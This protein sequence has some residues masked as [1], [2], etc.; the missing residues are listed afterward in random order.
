MRC[1]KPVKIKSTGGTSVLVRCG[2]CMS[3]RIDHSREWTARILLES[4]LH[5]Y[6]TFVT[7]TYDEE[8]LPPGGTL[9]K[10]ELSGFVKRLR[11]RFPP[12]SVRY[13][14]V[15]EYGDESGRP[16]YHIALF[17]VS[18]LSEQAVVDSW[19]D[20]QGN[21]LGFVKLDELN[22]GTAGYISQYVCKKWTNGDDLYVAERLKGRAPEFAIMSLRPGIGAGAAPIV[23]RAIEGRDT[24][25]PAKIRVDG[26]MRPLGRYIRRKI[27][28]E[29]PNAEALKKYEKEV[30][31]RSVYEENI[32]ET[33]AA[34][35]EGKTPELY[36]WEKKRQQFL[37]KIG[38]HKLHKKARRL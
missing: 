7:L 32:V 18:V 1:P 8:H 10:R 21:P 31:L 6:N 5:D 27:M 28:E 20:K 17:G 23:A 29:F 14:G 13:F 2:K 3:C 19:K 12:R 22:E 37:N 11:K 30:W 24:D 15:G 34:K 26:K 33:E 4:R 35:A 16:H 9:I 36:R 25:I 38:R